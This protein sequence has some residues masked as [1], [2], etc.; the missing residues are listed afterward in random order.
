MH[1]G[2]P[3][4]VEICLLMAKMTFSLNKKQKTYVTING[5]TISSQ[6]C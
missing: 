6:I 5:W 1:H 4:S 2:A 3:W